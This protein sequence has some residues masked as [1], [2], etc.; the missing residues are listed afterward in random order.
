MNVLADLLEVTATCIGD[1]VKETR[2]ILEDHGHDTG[3][4]PGPVR[5]RPG[6]AQLPGQRPAPRADRDNRTAIPPGTDRTHPRRTA[7]THRAARLPA[8]RPSRTPLLPAARRPTP[9]RCPGRRL[10]AEDQ[11]QR[12]R[13]AHHPL[14]QRTVHPGRPRRRPR[15]RQQVCRRQ[16]HPRNPPTAPAGRPH[17]RPG[18]DPLPHGGRS[19]RRRSTERHGDKLILYGFTTP[20]NLMSTTC[21]SPPSRGSPTLC[22]RLRAARRRIGARPARP[23]STR[24]TPSS[25]RSP[26]TWMRPA[27]TSWPSPP[28]P[29]RSGGRSGAATPRSG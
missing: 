22:T 23:V 25:P 18:T 5:H 4:C 10:P 15:R 26:L 3:S 21:P 29:R 14:P 7:R 6:P 9:A 1:L 20:R 27:T 17:S 28:S 2:E 13:P 8:V 24:S 19:P 11:Q 12:T 16:R